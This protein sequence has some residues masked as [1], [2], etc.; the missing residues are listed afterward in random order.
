MK[1][2][3]A[4]VAMTAIVSALSVSVPV[5]AAP[6]GE[7]TRAGYIEDVDLETGEVVLVD[8]CNHVWWWDGVTFQTP[9][10]PELLRS[11]YKVVIQI[12][13]RGTRRRKD[14]VVIDFE[15]YER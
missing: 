6:V 15:I 10:G 1:K 4:M 5:S 14:D 9:A 7:Y 8:E 3:V 2:I 12:D 11:G 13:G